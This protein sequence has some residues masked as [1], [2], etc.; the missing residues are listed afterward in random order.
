MAY[1][2]LQASDFNSVTIEGVAARAG[3]TK[4]TIYRWWSN[5]AEL[6]MDAFLEKTQEQTNFPNTGSVI[7]DFKRQIPLLIQAY[8]GETGHSVASVIAAGQMDQDTAEAFRTRYLAVRRAIAKMLIEQGIKQGVFAADLDPEIAVDL[9]YGP[10]Y[11]RLLVGHAP[12]D[13]NFAER[14]FEQALKGLLVRNSG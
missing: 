8:A 11:F 14:L 5:K 9:L 3:T 10:I 4:T 6:L 7:E 13:V 2:M 12:L 1:E